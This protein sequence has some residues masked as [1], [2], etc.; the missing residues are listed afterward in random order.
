[1]VEFEI[2]SRSASPGADRSLVM[3]PFARHDDSAENG[4]G[5]RRQF[6]LVQ[7]SQASGG[8]EESEV[9]TPGILGMISAR[10]L[11]D[12][13]TWEEQTAHV[14]AERIIVRAEIPLVNSLARIR[15][16]ADAALALTGVLELLARRFHVGLP[17]GDA[18]AEGLLFHAPAEINTQAVAEAIDGMLMGTVRSTDLQGALKD[19]ARARVVPAEAQYDPR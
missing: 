2:G 13:G 9:V 10:F 5:A 4:G 3:T 14:D 1:M 17:C 8:S 12:H 7:N 19:R 16:D 15:S 6:R 11:V 18:G